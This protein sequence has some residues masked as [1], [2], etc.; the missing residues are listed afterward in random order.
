MA[1]LLSLCFYLHITFSSKF[2]PLTMY[3]PHFYLKNSLGSGVEPS[4][5]Y[6]LSTTSELHILPVLLPLFYKDSWDYIGHQ[7]NNRISPGI[8][9]YLEILMSRT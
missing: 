9:E 2:G 7:N 8:L 1:A 3:A 4:T 6:I 5:L